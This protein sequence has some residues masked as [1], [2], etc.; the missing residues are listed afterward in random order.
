MITQVRQRPTLLALT[1]RDPADAIVQA[2]LVQQLKVIGVVPEQVQVMHAVPGTST[3]EW[4]VSVERHGQGGA[5]RRHAALLHALVKTLRT[6]P[7]DALY[8]REVVTVQLVFLARMLAQRGGSV[9]IIFDC[10]GDIAAEA[11]LR[12]SSRFRIAVLRFMQHRAW[13]GADRVMAVS[14]TLARHIQKAA[15]GIPVAV[16]PN[17]QPRI[18]NPV[19]SATPRPLVVFAGGAQAWQNSERVMDQ[20]GVLKRSGIDVVVISRDP[21]LRELAGSGGLDSSSGDRTHVLRSLQRAT[22]SWMVR[23]YAAANEVASP[24]KM[25]EALAAGALVIGSSSTWEHMDRLVADELAIQVAEAD[26]PTDLVDRLHAVWREGSA[27]RTRRLAT[28]EKNWTLEAYADTL[29]W[30][31][32]IEKAE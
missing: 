27:G 14:D 25:G 20:L 13:R 19:A 11:E 29:R 24:V 10:R 4:F 18:L 2:T 32:G 3:P 17:L 1:G 26:D 30:F 12:G 5:L 7:P 6:T 23:E 8:S 28:V 9:P 21:G 22:G 31:F 15:P 16:V